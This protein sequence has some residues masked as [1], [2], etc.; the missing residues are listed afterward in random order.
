VFVVI[1]TLEHSYGLLKKYNTLFLTEELNGAF[2]FHSF[3]IEKGMTMLCMT[4][5]VLG[6]GN[7]ILLTHNPFLYDLN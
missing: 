7:I 2:C 6:L 5:S 1:K 3:S 4:G